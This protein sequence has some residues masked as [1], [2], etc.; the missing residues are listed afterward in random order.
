MKSRLTKPRMRRIL[1]LLRRGGVSRAVAARAAGVAVSTL[2]NWT[3]RAKKEAGIYREFVRA[4][5]RAERA[6]EI[7]CAER[8]QLAAKK[9]WKAAAWYL[10][11]RFPKRWAKREYQHT[12]HSGAINGTLSFA[13]RAPDPDAVR[14]EI[15]AAAAALEAGK[16]SNGVPPNGH[17]NGRH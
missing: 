9:D 10:E 5:I 3:Q 17:T 4:M 2:Y 14:E 12:K 1:K 7:R 13:R 15:L 16:V 11:H 6:G 8:I